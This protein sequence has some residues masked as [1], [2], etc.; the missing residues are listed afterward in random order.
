MAFHGLQLYA[1]QFPK[2]LEHKLFAKLKEEIFDI[3]FKVKIIVDNEEER[4]D[5]ICNTKELKANEDVFL[6][7][8]CWTFKYREAEKTLRTNDKLLERMLN[9]CRYSQKQKLPSNPY[10]KKQLPLPEYLKS[11][12]DAPKHYDLD[13]YGIK[14]L[15]FLGFHEDTETISLFD[16]GVENPG[17]ITSVLYELPKLKALWLNGNPVVDNCVNFNQIGELL[18]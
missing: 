15:K 2:D 10:E 12:G 17:D 11:L 14:T 6:I 8:H 5:L 1:I 18:P 4:V 9:I 16:N 13:S 7:D 3:G